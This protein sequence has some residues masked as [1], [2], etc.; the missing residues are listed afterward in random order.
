M[1]I[2]EYVNGVLMFTNVLKRLIFL[3]EINFFLFNIV[4]TCE[5]NVKFLKSDILLFIILFLFFK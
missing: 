3:S 4:Y 2:T 5:C 1:L